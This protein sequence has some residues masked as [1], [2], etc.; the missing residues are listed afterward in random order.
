MADPKIL[1]RAAQLVTA[2]DKPAI[3]DGA[4]V[5]AGEIIEAVGTYDELSDRYPDAKTIGGKQFLLIPGLINGHSHGRGLT[6]FQRGVRDN[7]LE[8]WILDTRKHLPLP[9]YD[10]V[11]LSAGRLLK[12]GV[13]T[14]MHHHLPYLLGDPNTYSYE[15]D[16]ALRAYKD[17]GMRVQ[18]SP[19]IRN[20]NPFIYGDNDAFL[21][22][23][24]EKLQ[25]TLIA[26]FPSKGGLT[27]TNY[28]RVV[29]DLY[30]RFNGPMCRIGFG[31]SAPQWCTK[32]LL[33]EVRREADRLGAP[34]NI[35][36]L[37]SISQKIY[38]L[39]FL[40]KTLIHYMNDIGFLGPHLTIGHCVWPT[41]ADIEL[42][43]KTGTGV[44][45]NPSCNLRLRNGI[46][47]VFS[48]LKAG[49]LTGLGLDGSS[50]N[51]DDDLIQEMKVCFMLHRIPSFELDSSYVS[52]RQV[53]RMATENN[54]ILLG[55][56]RELGRL[57][58][59]KLADLVLLDYHQM[60]HPFVNPSH[61]P[62]DVLLYRG[63]GRHVHTVI[64]NGCIVIQDGQLLT[65]DEG[66]IAA[67]LAEA[68][69]RPRRPS[70][71]QW[72]N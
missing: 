23:L 19:A 47:P 4:V 36:A 13:T 21:S 32:E 16:E 30:I 67:R 40:G 57:E 26:T 20:S 72:M 63:L 28:V 15:F 7:T 10:D 71:R 70:F 31:P 68:G 64:V 62:I 14:T 55:Y 29:R 43:A 38:G 12:S 60:C 39:R 33:L 22:S 41:E 17:V 42:L 11:A 51:D 45:H 53:F 9:T 1:V 34:I 48:M 18:F 52:A 46:S 27:G 6:D 69:S 66:A 35:H 3:P 49:V 24:P 44:V 25:K 50:V 5:I 58:P 59:G 56:G 61:D 54:A 8:T 65:L 2:H 37:E